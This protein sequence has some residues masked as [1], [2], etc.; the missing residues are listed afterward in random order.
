MKK[1]VFLFASL[2][3]IV[4]ASQSVKAQNPEATANSDASATI[5]KVIG[6]ENTQYLF[7]GNIIASSAGGT[8]TVAS[9]GTAA[10]YNGVAAPTG[11]EGTRQPATFTVEGENSVA[12]SISLPE[13]DEITLTKNGATPMA[14][15]DFEHN[16][17]ETLSSGGTETFN[18]GA[19]LN[20]NP[21][22][23]TGT[24]EGQFSV[25]V[26]YN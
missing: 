13:D 21:D 5:I 14:L 24:Y 10:G 11:N 16:A 22:Q 12:Y 4:V 3:I 7:F 25:T 23:A 19:K 6:I 9:D 20:V 18:V 17:D 26:A 2:F 8:V 1:L 15:S